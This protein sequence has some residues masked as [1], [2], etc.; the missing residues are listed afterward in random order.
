MSCTSTP[1]G[2]E[3]VIVAAAG[4]GLSPAVCVSLFGALVRE[5]AGLPRPSDAD[6]ALWVSAVAARSAA[7]EG[8][9]AP[10]GPVL[11]P[12]SSVP[13]G[14]V[15]YALRRLVRRARRQAVVDTFGSVAV[16]LLPAGTDRARWQAGPDGRPAHVWYAAYG[17]NTDFARLAVYVGGGRPP[18]GSRTYLG[19]RDTTRPE[20][21]VPVLLPGLVQFAGRSSAWGGSS[22]GFLD[23]TGDGCSLGRA[24]L[25]TSAQLDD[26]V[27]QETGREVDGS[28]CGLTA[29]LA[30]G[31]NRSRRAYGTVVHVGDLWGAPVVTATGPWTVNE[32]L[33]G[34]GCPG[35]DLVPPRSGRPSA[36]Y[37]RTVHR[38]L[39]QTFGV[40][41]RDT[42]DYLAGSPGGDLWDTEALAAALDDPG[43]TDAPC[44]DTS[45]ADAARVR[46]TAR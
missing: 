23:P 42:A 20:A 2:R 8:L 14:P 24:W 30:S 28:L 7:R 33:L 22:V 15:F 16:P 13:E 10:A 1:E 17:T 19:C 21:G 45:C 46:V 34:P 44:A 37:A 38:G 12:V 41:A 25:V 3:V 35:T 27:A 4:S 9:P 32:V 29:A 18:G 40:S 26:L 11:W 43:F 39:T 5:G 36:A 6:W 31:R